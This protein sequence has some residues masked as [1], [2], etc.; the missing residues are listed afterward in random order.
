[1]Y[2]KRIW[3]SPH[4]YLYGGN[5]H[6]SHTKTTHYD[7]YK[8]VFRIIHTGRNNATWLENTQTETC[9]ISRDKARTYACPCTDMCVSINSPCFER[10]HSVICSP[11]IC[12]DQAL[13]WR[14]QQL[15]EWSAEGED[16]CCV[17]VHVNIS[18]YVMRA[19]AY[20]DHIWWCLI[21]TKKA[22]ACMRL[23]VHT[24]DNNHA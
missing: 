8:Y 22:L 12:R 15:S 2:P 13:W 1:L 18:L 4:N 10:R 24:L 23:C 17:C 7:L 5:N 19:C 3:Y 11:L 9:F 14:P 21:R 20:F 16:T 6:Y